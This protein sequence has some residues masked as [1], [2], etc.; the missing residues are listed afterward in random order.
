MSVCVYLHVD[1][2]LLS[3]LFY[4]TGSLTEPMVYIGEAGQWVHQICLSPLRP[5]GL[6]TQV[7]MLAEQAL[8]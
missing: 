8:F 2:L 3:L 6:G 4:K 1:F 5:A 7:L